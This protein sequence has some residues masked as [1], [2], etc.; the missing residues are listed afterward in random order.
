MPFARL[1]RRFGLFRKDPMSTAKLSFELP[2]FPKIPNE[3]RKGRNLNG[4]YTRGWGIQYG[5]LAEK[6]RQDPLYRDAVRFADGRS[7]Q[8]EDNRMNMFLLMAFYFDA[9]PPGNIVEFGTFRG[10]SALFMA[11][12]CQVLHP[13]TRIYAFDTFEG[14]PE[15]NA[16]VD[17][18]NIGDFNT[19]DLGEI[20]AYAAAHGL[21]NI[22]FVKG[23][24]EDTLPGKLAEIGPIRLNHIDCD[25]HSGVVYSYEATKPNM[26]SGG[27]IVL[28][29]PLYSSCIGAYEAVED[30]FVRRD[31][32]NAEQVFPHL[33]YRAV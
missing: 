24:F 3:M 17:A 9:L 30:I 12:V 28:D 16:D 22:E 8:S 14:M 1:A 19:A 33:V 21:S 13:E 27:Y 10:G 20:R 32:L 26:V 11:R 25:I 5:D 7:V 4:G 23:L 2:I 18:H 6:I 15:T 31:N 29:D